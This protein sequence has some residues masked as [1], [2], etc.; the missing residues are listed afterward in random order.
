MKTH[1]ITLA[2]LTL[3]SLQAP[4]PPASVLATAGDNQITLSWFEVSCATSYNIYRSDDPSLCE[5]SYSY[6]ATTTDLEYI[7]TDVTNGV[8]YFYSVSAVNVCGVGPRSDAV[9]AIP[10]APNPP[11]LA[12]PNVL[13]IMTD[14]QSV[15][16]LPY[17]SITNAIFNDHSVHF[18]NFQVTTPLCCPSRAIFLTGNYA[19]RHGVIN[20]APVT[21][22]WE[23]FVSSGAEALALPVWLRA[24]GYKNAFVGTYMKGYQVS[25][26]NYVPPGWDSWFGWRTVGEPNAY[27]NYTVLDDIDGNGP[28]AGV[29]RSYGNTEAE[30]ATTVIRDRA[31]QVITNTQPTTPLFLYVAFTAPHGP[32]IAL[33][34]DMNTHTGVSVPQPPNFNESD[35]SDKPAWIRNLQPAN[36]TTLTTQY[37][38]QL[39]TLASV[40]RAIGDIVSAFGNRPTIIFYTSDN[41]L[42]E[43]RHR[44]PWKNQLLASMSESFLLVRDPLLAPGVR[45]DNALTGNISIA[46]TIAERT[47]TTIPYTPNGVSLW[48]RLLNP[49]VPLPDRIL[50]EVAISENGQIP[51]GTAIVTAS[52]HQLGAWRYVEYPTTGESILID[53]VND[54]YALDSK[55]AH[56]GIHS[57][58]GL[59]YSAIKAQLAAELAQL[60]TQ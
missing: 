47:G 22:G 25:P 32:S 6:F 15:S 2:F 11:P 13:V 20:H 46:P 29:T 27:Y 50:I 43:G 14:D 31:I 55:H 3:V 52:W 1:F 12:K 60:R 37:R 59:S 24:S 57:D 7:D 56:T 33:S 8:E 35:V 23:K 21:G 18:T 36:V 53:I 58:T 30:Y 45:V 10:Q 40:D 19:H 38:K 5:C 9:S 42:S 28:T 54:P 49:L 26:S 34:Q 41:G 4:Y 44:W 16:S 48:A 17:M 51:P 39:D